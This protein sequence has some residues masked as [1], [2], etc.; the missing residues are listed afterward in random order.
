MIVLSSVQ[1]EN[2]LIVFDHCHII[3]LIMKDC[4]KLHHKEHKVVHN[5]Q[6]QCVT[7]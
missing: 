6:A 5:V 7:P 4:R 2:L 3:G 1:Y